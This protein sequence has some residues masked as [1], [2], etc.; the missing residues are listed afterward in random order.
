LNYSYLKDP[1]QSPLGIKMINHSVDMILSMGLEQFTFKKLALDIESTEASIY[2]Y[3]E[4]KHQLLLYLVSAYWEGLFNELDQ[5]NNQNI[6]C[7]L[8]L[9]YALQL[10]SGVSGQPVF[11]ASM[12][13]EKLRCIVVAESS[14]SYHTVKVDEDN[15]KGHF[16]PYK[17]FSYLLAE[18]VRAV[19]PNYPYPSS[20]VSTMIETALNE[21]FFSDH[22]PS[23]T[24]LKSG[25]NIDHQLYQFLSDLCTRVLQVSNYPASSSLHST[26][27]TSHR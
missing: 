6:A 12:D 11:S 24:E 14:K 5:K 20:L 8:K 25:S 21:R 7:M 26:L 4:N 3:F 13:G 15:K 2:R 22:L 10:I 23:L 17:R 1:S 16:L 19:N 9:D 27:T 18:L